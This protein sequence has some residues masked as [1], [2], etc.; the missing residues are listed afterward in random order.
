MAGRQTR[1]KWY[2][3]FYTYCTIF[4]DDSLRSVS[5]EKDAGFE[6]IPSTEKRKKLPPLRAL[7]SRRAGFLEEARKN[8]HHQVTDRRGAHLTRRSG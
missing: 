4:A 6:F 5:G 2:V 3:N 7:R 8:L 1:F